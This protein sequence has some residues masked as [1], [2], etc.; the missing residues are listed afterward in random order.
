MPPPQI[1][2][3]HSPPCPSVLRQCRGSL[4]LNHIWSPG[5]DSLMFCFIVQLYGKAH[6]EEVE[7]KLNK[8]V[9]S[10]GTKCL[11]VVQVTWCGGTF[12]LPIWK[13]FNFYSCMSLWMPTHA[14]YFY[15]SLSCKFNMLDFLKLQIWWSGFFLSSGNLVGKSH[16]HSLPPSQ[17]CC[18]YA[19][20]LHS[21]EGQRKLL[22]Q[23][24]LTTIKRECSSC[25]VL[26]VT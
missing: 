4:Y 22:C 23:F 5:C 7:Q 14:F 26:T 13:L 21:L 9:D 24:L 20:I 2:L 18:S 3:L 10:T 19:P 8:L 12:L 1:P 11:E 17:L 16:A 15:V 25:S 6:Q